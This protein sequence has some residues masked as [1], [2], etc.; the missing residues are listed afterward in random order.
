MGKHFT[1]WAFICNH[2]PVDI[3]QDIEKKQ[4]LEAWCGAFQ[5]GPEVSHIA[6]VCEVQHLQHHS[7]SCSWSS[8]PN[9]VVGKKN[10]FSRA[11]TQMP[12]KYGSTPKPIHRLVY[13]LACYSS[14]ELILPLPASKSLRSK[15][16]KSFQ[17]IHFHWEVLQDQS[18]KHQT[19]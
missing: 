8:L 2:P 5:A 11:D 16:T 18:L 3:T 17:I 12:W 4:L 6:W 15:S 13:K 19:W 14:G 7:P 9:I 1:G 10:T